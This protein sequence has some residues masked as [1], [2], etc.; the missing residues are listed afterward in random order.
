MTAARASA[1]G[2]GA[3]KKVARKG[4]RERKQNRASARNTLLQKARES[5]GKERQENM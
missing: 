5:G 3:W 2:G 4:C 1:E